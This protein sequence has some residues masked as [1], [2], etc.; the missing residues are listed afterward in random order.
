MQ[1]NA[2]Y[3]FK[4]CPFCGEFPRYLPFKA[5]F[6][7]ERVI[8]DTCEFHLTPNEWETRKGELNEAF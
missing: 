2:N 7:Y 1:Y 3:K 6:Y 5:G 8:C 4:V